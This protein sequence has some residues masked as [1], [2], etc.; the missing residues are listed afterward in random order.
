MCHSFSYTSHRATFLRPAGHLGNV[1]Q[2]LSM[3][4]SPGTQ[5]K[6]RLGLRVKVRDMPRNL[7]CTNWGQSLCARAWTLMTADRQGLSGIIKPPYT[8][9]AP[10]LTAEI[11]PLGWRR[12]LFVLTTVII[13]VLLKWGCVWVT[14]CVD[15]G[16]FRVKNKLHCS[17]MEIVVSL[18]NESEWKTV[19][20][21]P[22]L[23]GEPVYLAPFT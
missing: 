1:G 18:L 12:A 16:L 11:N 14:Q 15:V 7:D 13:V 9:P 6:L 19:I 3:P 10:D 23:F 20:G 21:I 22:S 4:T 2:N 8:L 17:L 5:L